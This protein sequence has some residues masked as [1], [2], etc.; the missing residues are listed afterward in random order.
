MLRFV[1]M[2]RFDQDV[3]QSINLFDMTEAALLRGFANDH[4]K[5]VIRS[6]NRPGLP[7]VSV[8]AAAAVP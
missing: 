3:E 1:F 8:A 5:L 7:E 6:I 4:E 2:F